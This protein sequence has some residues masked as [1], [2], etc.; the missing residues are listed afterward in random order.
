MKLREFV[1]NNSSGRHSM[2]AANKEGKARKT[3]IT[4]RCAYPD[5]EIVLLKHGPFVCIRSRGGFFYV[6][7]SPSKFCSDDRSTVIGLKP[8]FLYL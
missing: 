6:V 3:A 1:Y 4:I 2:R 5:K 8:L 7:L